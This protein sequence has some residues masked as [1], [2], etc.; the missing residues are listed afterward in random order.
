MVSVPLRPKQPGP[1]PACQIPCQIGLMA[2]TIWRA[3]ESQGGCRIER[4]A[5][6]RLRSCALPSPSVIRS[7]TV[8]ACRPRPRGEQL[9]DRV[10]LCPTRGLTW[11]DGS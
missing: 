3:P 2:L 8:V 4:Q 7:L 6:C 1:E 5:H 10:G 9:R 11:A